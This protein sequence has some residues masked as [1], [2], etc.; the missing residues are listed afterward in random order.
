M[1]YLFAAYTI[2]WLL[3]ITYVFVLGRRQK[4][5]VKELEFLKDLHDR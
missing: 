5:V 3:I 4:Q 2:I 1:E